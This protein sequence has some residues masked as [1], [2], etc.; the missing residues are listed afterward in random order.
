MKSKRGWCA[1][2]SRLSREP[3]M[4]LSTPTTS[5]SRASSDSHRWDPMNPAA[6]VTSTRIVALRLVPGDRSS[7]RQDGLAADRVVLE[8]QPAHPLGLPEVAAVEDHRTAQ[9]AAQALEVEE[10]EL[11]PLRDERHRI[12]PA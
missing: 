9:H 2:G 3:V 7:G 5:Q 6:P 11:V 1:T 4:K 12:R 8:A 10:L